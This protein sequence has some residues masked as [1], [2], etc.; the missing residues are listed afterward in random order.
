MCGFM[1]GGNGPSLCCR[2]DVNRA[3]QIYK[4]GEKQTFNDKLTSS[5]VTRMKTPD[6]YRRILTHK[7]TKKQDKKITANKDK[8]T[9]YD[10]KRDRLTGIYRQKEDN[11]KYSQRD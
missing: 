4:Q 8:K 5:S 10:E 3:R 11:T 6:I 7:H 9:T 1:M 2:A